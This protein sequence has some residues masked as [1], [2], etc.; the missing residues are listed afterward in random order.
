MK[1]SI[2]T[3]VVIALLATATCRAEDSFDSNGTK[4][5]YTVA[6]TGEPVVLVHGFIGSSEEWMSP[7][8][9]LPPNQKEKFQ[10]IFEALSRQYMVIALDCRGHGKSGKPKVDN[11]YGLEM[12]ED[13]VRLLDHLELEQA[14]VVGYSMGAFLSAK[15]VAAHADRVKSVVLGGGG[16][17]LEGSEQLAFMVSLGES[18]A[19][20]KGVEPLILAMTPPGQPEPTP[21]QIEAYN[22]MFLANQDEQALAKAALGHKQLTVSK[23]LLKSNEVPALLIVGGNDPLK[24]ASE[25]TTKLL[26]NSRLIVLDGQDHVST[27]LSP[28][29]LKNIRRFL[30][31]N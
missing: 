23:E 7:P 5:C 14:H 16:A 24:A 15:L 17:L 19:S 9:F 28:D 3:A 26:S 31:E 29:F 1:T 13:I 8:P 2:G 4:I 10:T 21:E 18:L 12:V 20:G 25:E 22:K 6:G 27:E 11:Q 30:E